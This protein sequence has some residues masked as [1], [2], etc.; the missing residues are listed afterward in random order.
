MDKASEAILSLKP[1]TF[2]YKYEIDPEGTPHFGPVAEDV[3]NV[4]PIWCAMRQSESVR[5]S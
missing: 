3:E 2:Y 5:L 1:V 4:N